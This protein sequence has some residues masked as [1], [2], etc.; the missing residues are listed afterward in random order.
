MIYLGIFHLLLKLF[1][2]AHGK[3]IIDF[4]E[5]I[6]ILRKLKA[7]IRFIDREINDIFKNLNVSSI[8]LLDTQEEAINWNKI[9]FIKQSFKIYS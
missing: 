6:N 9:E 2:F 4:K 8:K 5:I 7:A 3:Q 1:S